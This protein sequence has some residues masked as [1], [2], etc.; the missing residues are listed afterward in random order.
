MDSLWD[1]IHNYD[2]SFKEDDRLLLRASADGTFLLNP[3]WLRVKLPSPN[4][5]FE[6]D[7]CA[8]LSFYNIRGV[9]PRNK[10]PGELVL[11]DQVK[12]AQNHYRVLYEDTKMPAQLR[13][14][15]H[16]AQL[17]SAEAQ[18]R[19]T[20]FIDGDIDL[21]SSSTTFEVGVDLGDLETVFLRNVPPEPFN[22]T[23]RVG[24]AGRGGEIPGL[25]LTYCRRNP[26]DLYHYNDPETH[27]LKGQIRPPQL[28][29]QNEKIIL[30]HIT[31]TVLSAFFRN[32]SNRERFKKVENLI[33]SDW[34]NPSAVSEVMN[35]CRDNTALASS[36][37]EI[38]PKEMH[39]KTGLDNNSWMNLIA[40]KN[41]R[42][43]NAEAEVCSEYLL[44][45]RLKK[46][47]SREDNFTKAK[48]FQNRANTIAA[49]K[50]LNFLSRKAII[51]KY[52]F[53]VD[54]VELDTRPYSQQEARKISLQRDLSQA[55]AEYAPGGKVVANKKEWQS[56]GIK[57]IAGK[58]LAV[59]NYYYNKA[60]DFKQWNEDDDQAG[61]P[62]PKGKYLSPEFGFVTALLEKPKE[63]QGRAGRLYTTR[64][65][66]GGFV[67]GQ[68]ETK[69][70]FDVEITPALPGRMVV[71]CEGKNGGGF[72]ICL[73]CGAGSAEISGS[74]KTPESNECKSTLKRLSLGHEFVTDVVRLQFPGLNDEWHAY[75]LAYAMLLGAAQRLNVPDTD[76]NATITVGKTLDKT[77]IV[78]YDNVPGGAGLVA[79]L[80]K[81][82]VFLDVLKEAKKR[83]NG[84]C[85]CTKSC[86]GC[87]RS[88]RNQ[89]AHPHLQR[90]DALGFLE[91]AL[92]LRGHNT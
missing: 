3:A 24:R 92:E 12:L 69:K 14:E 60:R 33:G 9:C 59:K 47:F 17:E 64:P 19:Q 15:E 13:A 87:I 58:T 66:F 43:A 39:A 82:D 48:K 7:T 11:A 23:Q 41:S 38:V 5:C 70:L 83:V 67:E 1:C 42:F 53:P 74:H 30:R 80:E 76:L 89:F 71:L 16:T 45:E 73:S 20:E 55:I 31:A 22:Y 81:Q 28:R 18:K 50:T 78:L 61:N 63:P 34:E 56:C 86:Y 35:F 51:P 4:E 8:R 21:L 40:G 54:V 84:D 44:V 37:R 72:Y 29:L 57:I 85:D 62:D 2:S 49:D 68:Q 52:G 91:S 79:N 36:L 32:P 90:K 65:F 88:Y 77:A 10:C 75:S 27:I 26:H 6:C 46:E 25:A